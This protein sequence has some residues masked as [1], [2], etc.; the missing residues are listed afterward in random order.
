MGQKLGGSDTISACVSLPPNF[1]PTLYLG[2][3]EVFTAADAAVLRGFYQLSAV[4]RGFYQ[5]QN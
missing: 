2:E 3:E 1:W 5:D 4:L